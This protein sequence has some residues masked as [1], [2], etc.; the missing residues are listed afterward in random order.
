MIYGT[1]RTLIL[2]GVVTSFTP[3]TDHSTTDDSAAELPRAEVVHR[4]PL[5][6]RLAGWLAALLGPSPAHERLAGEL[7]V[8]DIERNYL[9]RGVEGE[10]EE[11]RADIERCLERAEEALERHETELGWRFLYAAR[12]IELFGLAAHDPDAFCARV[13]ATK[14]EAAQKL[15]GW[16]LEAVEDLLGSGED[17]ADDVDVTDAYLAAQL[18]QEH[19]DTYYQKVQI[20]RR[21]LWRLVGVAGLA[22]GLLVLLAGVGGPILGDIGVTSFRMLPVVVL[23]GVLGASVSGV[24]SLAH[25]GVDGRL[26]QQLLASWVTYAR[27]VIGAAS[28]LVMLAFLTSGLAAIVLQDVVLTPGSVLFVAFASGFSERLLVRAIESV[29]GGT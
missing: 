17:P 9:L 20:H 8:Y 23:F 2:V 24:L 4:R 21:Q 29:S 12:R 13:R 6:G 10:D 11:W 14:R 26:S 22:V 15:G 16:R 18:L 3:M 5:R 1:R 7:A 25:G 27:L 28:A 19:Y